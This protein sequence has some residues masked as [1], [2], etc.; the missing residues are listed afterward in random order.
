MTLYGD[1][2]DT[3]MIEFGSNITATVLEK[4]VAD[5]VYGM[6]NI[7]STE[8]ITIGGNNGKKIMGTVESYLDGD[9]Y[10]PGYSFIRYEFE[11]NNFSLPVRSL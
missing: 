3:S 6:E 2:D 1:M 7:T 11:K 8:N 10:E 9:Y 5:N 4:Y